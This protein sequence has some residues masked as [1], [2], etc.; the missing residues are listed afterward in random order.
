MAATAPIP[1]LKAPTRGGHHGP[2]C[3]CFGGGGGSGGK[4]SSAAE[5]SLTVLATTRKEQRDPAYAEKLERYRNK[6]R[7]TAPVADPQRSLQ[8]SKRKRDALG[9]FLK[10]GDE[11]VGRRTSA[12]IEE[13]SVKN[14]GNDDRSGDAGRTQAQDLVHRLRQREEA[15]RGDEESA[16]EG[17]GETEKNEDEERRRQGE[18]SS[19][20]TRVD[21]LL[22]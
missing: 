16:M 14:E 12:R 21:F 5:L 15:Q 20:R 10:E 11:G 2:N 7:R 13:D 1:I 8:A 9:K 22:N 19:P 4:N 18:E 17:S 6:M 3:T